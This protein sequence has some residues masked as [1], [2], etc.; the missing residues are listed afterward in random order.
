MLICWNWPLVVGFSLLVIFVCLLCPCWYGVY[1]CSTSTVLVMSADVYDVYVSKVKY[2][3]DHFKFL[4]F[5]M[6]NFLLDGKRKATDNKSTGNADG[7]KPKSRSMM[8]VTHLFVSQVFCNWKRLA[9]D[10]C[11]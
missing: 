4:N 10:C 11:L 7:S 6:V 5:Q 2:F 3:I 8:K 1:Y 9:S